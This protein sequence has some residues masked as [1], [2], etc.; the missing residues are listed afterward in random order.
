MTNDQKWR[1]NE[2]LRT[3]TQTDMLGKNEESNRGKG[4]R[5]GVSVLTSPYFAEQA[6][7][8]IANVVH[9]RRSTPLQTRRVVTNMSN[10]GVEWLCPISQALPVDHGRPRSP[11]PSAGL[12]RLGRAPGTAPNE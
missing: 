2:L 8:T 11:E 5:S 6:M 9:T 7:I 3:E 10:V 4:L 12:P 1:R